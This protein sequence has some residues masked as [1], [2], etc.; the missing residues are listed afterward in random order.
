MG[1]HAQMP[2]TQVGFSRAGHLSSPPAQWLKHQQPF[3][4]SHTFCG[5]G[6]PEGLGQ[7]GA[8]CK[9][10][11][12]SQS[13]ADWSWDSVELAW[14]LPPRQVSVLVRP[15]LQPGQFPKRTREKWVA[16]I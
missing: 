14:H 12:W 4:I 8:G 5:A 16:F 2:A 9:S 15:S 1:C 13:G 7:A 10:P 6:V 3:I 11:L